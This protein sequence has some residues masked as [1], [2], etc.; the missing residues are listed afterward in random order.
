MQGFSGVWPL[1]GALGEYFCVGNKAHTGPRKGLTM[2]KN[3]G[4]KSAATNDTAEAIIIELPERPSRDTF[5]ARIE[6]SVNESWTLLY[7]VRTE[8]IGNGIEDVGSTATD[9][10]IGVRGL[11]FV[12]VTYDQRAA[13]DAMLTAY[14]ND[15]KNAGAEQRTAKRVAKKLAA[16][17][18]LYVTARRTWDNIIA[19]KLQYATTPPDTF[20]FQMKARDSRVELGAYDDEELASLADRQARKDAGEAGVYVGTVYPTLTVSIVAEFRN[21]DGGGVEMRYGISKWNYGLDDTDPRYDNFMD[22]LASATETLQG[23]VD[24]ITQAEAARKD[25]TYRALQ[26]A[27]LIPA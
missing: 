12:D 21:R 9:Y 7:A 19:G 14:A 8:H 15:P 20:T 23:L 13:L 26:A 27:G 16:I 18:E 2:T 6:L 10:C 3:T 4:T 1:G 24:E 25:A 22:A 17:E 5:V 11:S